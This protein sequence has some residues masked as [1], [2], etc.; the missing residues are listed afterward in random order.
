[1]GE[2][3]VLE[4]RVHGIAN[5]P[6]ADMLLTEPDGVVKV[7]GD[8]LG[9]FW[10]RKDADTAKPSDGLAEHRVEAYSWGNQARTGGSGLALI[11]RAFVHL[12]WLFILPFALCNL[13]YW[14][15]RSIPGPTDHDVA[16]DKTAQEKKDPVWV[17][18]PGATWIRIFA[19]LQ[20]LF[21]TTGFMSV[22]VD[23]IAVQCFTDDPRQVC[24]A[25]PQWIDGL[26][27][28]SRI[29]RSALL[30]I[31]PI[32]LMAVI[33][34]IARRAR[35]E[36]DPDRLAAEGTGTETGGGSGTGPAAEPEAVRDA[37]SAKG[38]RPPLLAARSFWSESRI[39]YTTERAHFAGVIALVLF[40]LAYDALVE[41]ARTI[42]WP[43]GPDKF[44]SFVTW[45]GQ[46][47]A[48]APWPFWMGVV[49]AGLLVVSAGIVILGGMSGRRMPTVVKR[50]L[51]TILLVAS[52]VAYAVWLGWAIWGSHDIGQ[53]GDSTFVGLEVTP[54][55]IATLCALIAVAS[56]SWGYPI[57]RWFA[58]AL[59]VLAFASVVLA[60]IIPHLFDDGSGDG[61]RVVLS[62]TAVA[63]VAIT[64]GVG[65]FFHDGAEKEIRR[66][67]GWHGNG[68]AVILLLALLASMVITSLLVI[69][70]YAWLTTPAESPKTVQF[71]RQLP[72]QAP[73][74]A[75]DTAPASLTPPDF[76][77]RFA[78]TLLA[79]LVVV[80]L[81]AAVVSFFAF[82]RFPKFSVPPLSFPHG[83][84][85]PRV[86]QDANLLGIEDPSV[87]DPP[88]A[89]PRYPQLEVKPADRARKIAAARQFAGFAHR[90]EPL[91]AALAIL[92]ALALVPLTVPWIAEQIAEWNVWPG[93][94]SVA[95]WALGLLAIAAATYVIT[96]AVTA[97]DRPLGLVWDIFCFFPRAGHPFTP[98]CWAER[99]VP[100]LRG[101]LEK[102]LE[103]A[104]ATDHYV[105]I[106][107]HS[108]GA[109]IAIATI[110]SIWAGKDSPGEHDA[111]ADLAGRGA[112]PAG[113][114]K[115]SVAVGAKP[116]GR[117]A[118]L[119]YGV[120]LRAYF[121]RF[122]P[123]VFGPQVLGAPGTLRPHL[124]S[125]DPW[126]A[127][128][129][130]EWGITKRQWSRSHTARME[131]PAAPEESRQSWRTPVHPT[132]VE[133]LGGDLA[134]GKPPRWRNL[135]RRTD[136]L[137]FPAAGYKGNLI[138]HGASERA[139]REYVWLI[140]RHNDYLGTLQYDQA[141]DDLL[142]AWK[143]RGSS[144]SVTDLRRRLGWS[145][146]R[147]T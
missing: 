71:W 14:S 84:S 136:F 5:A 3:R 25:L 95:G 125:R 4:V 53:S 60:E 102:W 85:V 31:A 119:T 40:L 89:R 82:V 61:W 93:V 11:G 67:T 28:W 145:R 76:Y 26:E 131:T 43:S 32:L 139:P 120:Q 116:I 105:I 73:D 75:P 92:T 39:A 70:M 54:G 147:R 100:E 23:L 137:G 72:G 103:T 106:S 17:G 141:V 88:G 41:A 127:Q 46:L 50:V 56:L 104:P 77:V 80:A 62:W 48:V 94:T 65:Y 36:Y 63:I 91:L 59:V 135:W 2:P 140:A 22:F 146:R 10:Q 55:V 29:A 124:L 47:V 143:A 42:P 30:S 129:R 113:P 87:P 44:A 108:M 52:V 68:A 97:T 16:K 122:F 142:G 78:V 114:A 15:R 81:I 109:P 12:G 45:F 58:A 132:L 19:L 98:P 34:L 20:T 117:V 110:F 79:M 35:G 21:Y 51:A 121:G 99:T 112:T 18:G 6:P 69:G 86:D 96:D 38:R 9:S 74:A 8:A 123:E 57:R 90:G 144:P 37:V 128:V 24:A 13:A 101:R 138:D 7:E 115:P 27:T 126:A 83:T 49:G 133:V 134:V 130:D 33:Y 107:A 118:L 66:R 111:Q 64:V 1:M